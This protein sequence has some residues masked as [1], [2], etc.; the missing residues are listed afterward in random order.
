MDLKRYLVIF[1]LALLAF[2][3]GSPKVL[4]SYKSDAATFEASGNYARATEAWINYF[5]QTPVEEVAGADFAAAAKTAYKG[6]SNDLAL[7][8]FDQARYKNYSDAEMYKIMANIYGSVNNLSKELSALEFFTENFGEGDPDVNARLFEIYFEIDSYEQ[9]LDAWS[10]MDDASKNE[11]FSLSNYFIINKKLENTAVCDSVSMALLEKNPEQ[12]DAL[13]YNAKK[14]YWRGENRYQKEL[15]KYEKNKTNKQY[16]ILLKEL[17]V[18]SADL[19]KSLLY[20]EKIWK[21]EKEKEFASYF[22]SIYGRFGDE[23]KS[24]YYQGFMK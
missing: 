9:A 15:A 5:N 12:M 6:E 19:K 17:E 18:A 22:A 14:Y 21:V 10:K 4:T 8:W 3:C 2:G 1:G 16:K 13:K 23:K 20:L 11:E 7:G 24:K